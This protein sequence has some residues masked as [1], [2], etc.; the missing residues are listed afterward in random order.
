MLA[1]VLQVKMRE[2]REILNAEDDY[3]SHRGMLLTVDIGRVFIKPVVV[4]D[5]E[6]SRQLLLEKSCQL[7]KG[8][9]K[10]IFS[11]PINVLRHDVEGE[12]DTRL[13]ENVSYEPLE[14]SEH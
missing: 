13:L 6:I 4:S 11:L 12:A 5:D 8:Q 1:V 3:F 10:K 9:V 7:V 14:V 2:L